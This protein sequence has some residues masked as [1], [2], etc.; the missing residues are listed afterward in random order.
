M[1]EKCEKIFICIKYSIDQIYL[2]G[3]NQIGQCVD[4]FIGGC[5]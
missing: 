1:K 5:P 4:N 3:P 2:S